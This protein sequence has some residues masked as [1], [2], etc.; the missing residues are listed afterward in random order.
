MLI[1]EE[2]SLEGRLQFLNFGVQVDVGVT[3]EESKMHILGRKQT[4]SF[5]YQ[6][7]RVRMPHSSPTCDLTSAL[8]PQWAGHWGRRQGSTAQHPWEAGAVAN[9]ASQSS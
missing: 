4:R 2:Q 5:V 1:W 9:N 6:P 3:Q 8:A 7:D